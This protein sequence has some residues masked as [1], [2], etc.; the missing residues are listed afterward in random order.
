LVTLTSLGVLLAQ[1]R[2]AALS[3]FGIVIPIYFLRSWRRRLLYF[4]ILLF[5]IYYFLISGSLTRGGDLSLTDRASLQGV[6]LQAIATYPLFGTGSQ[7]SIS[8]Y[9]SIAPNFRLLQ[10][11]HDSFTLFLSWFGLFSVLAL[12]LGSDLLRKSWPTAKMF[13]RTSNTNGET[14]SDT[15]SVLLPLLPLPPLLLLDHYLLTSPQGL[16]ILLL[17]LSCGEK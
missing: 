3:L 6:S 13:N 14:R 10:P 4:S 15:L 7:A 11:D 9:T 2:A 12:F 8:T 16:F 5:A 1:S 17:Y